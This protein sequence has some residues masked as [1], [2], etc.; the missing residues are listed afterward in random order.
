[1]LNAIE[2]ASLAAAIAALPVQGG[3]IY[4]PALHDSL[5]NVRPYVLDATLTISKPV[6]LVGDGRGA[7]VLKPRQAN[8]RFH[9]LDLR[10][11]FVQVER[12]SID[13]MADRETGFDCVQVNGL[14]VSGNLVQHC[15]LRDVEI[16]RAGRNALRSRDAIIFEADNCQFIFSQSDG[17]HID[18]GDDPTRSATTTMRFMNS[19]FSQNAGRGAYLPRNGAGITFFGCVF[20]GNDGGS[21]SKDGAGLTARSVSRLELYSCYFE[22]PPPGGG[23]QFLRFESC[24]SV[25]VEGCLFYTAPGQRKLLRAAEF[26]NSRWARFANNVAERCSLEVVRFDSECEGAVEFGNRDLDAPAG[27]T[28]RIAIEGRGVTSLSSGAVN[29]G[30]Y[31][32]DNRPPPGRRPGGAL[33]GSLIW[34]EDPDPSRG[35]SRL[36]VSDGSAWRNIPVVDS[37]KRSVFLPAVTMRPRAGPS[38]IA[39][40]GTYPNRYSY[41]AW[42]AT[43]TTALGLEW[44]VPPD[45]AKGSALVFSVVWSCDVAEANQW[46]CEV[47]YLARRDGESMTARGTTLTRRI[48]TDRVSPDEASFEVLGSAATGLAPGE[49]VRLN[50]A[51]RGSDAGDTYTG[52]VRLIGLIVQYSVGL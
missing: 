30:R 4:L 5:G 20:E 29:L 48:A 10:S 24:P 50:V 7:T 35:E 2:Y 44:S 45:Y 23:S 46:A 34:R 36:Q 1:M 9:L 26:V 11:S 38:T 49:V 43:G 28:P 8:P 15:V 12:M 42:P 31:F 22:D 41:A 13:G 32:S 19:A 25:L 18:R 47:D 17:A 52:E 16:M 39:E 21:G 33:P 27:G 14:G 51:R 40:A 6:R 37:V 3:E